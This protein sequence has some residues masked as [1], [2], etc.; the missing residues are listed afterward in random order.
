MGIRISVYKGAVGLWG[1]PRIMAGHGLVKPGEIMTWILLKEAQEREDL[2][3]IFE[4]APD[5][6]PEPEEKS[7]G[8]SAPKR[9]VRKLK[10][11]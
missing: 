2:Q 3:P 5:F 4:E 6:A 9:G 7:E 10:L 8:K 1:N 11:F